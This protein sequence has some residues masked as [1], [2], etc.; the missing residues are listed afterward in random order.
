MDGVGGASI[1]VWRA[2]RD[3]RLAQTL[4]EGQKTARSGM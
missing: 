1:A 4:R 3:T 2:A